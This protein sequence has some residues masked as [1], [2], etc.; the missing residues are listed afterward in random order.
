MKLSKNQLLFI[1]TICLP[2]LLFSQETEKVENEK[3]VFKVGG[4][5]RFNY[6]YSNWKEGHEKRGGDFGYD[7]LA[8]KPTASYKGI[9]LNAELRFYSTAFGG[10]MLKQ[11]WF[12]YHFSEKNQIQLGL[13]QVPFGITTYNSHNWFF[14]I[15]YYVG[16]E[17][18]HDMGI[19][20]MH[21][22]EKWEYNIAFFKNAEEMVFGSNSDASMSRYSYDAGSMDEN[23]DG[24][25]QYRNKEVNQFNGS[26][27][28]KF[29]NGDL[30]GKLGASGMYGGLYNLDTESTGSHYAAA[31]HFEMDYKKWNLKLQALHYKWDPKAPDGERTDVIAMVAYGAPY[32]V[33]A[34]ASSY[35]I[36]ASFNQPVE[37][38]PVSSLTFYNDFG[39]MDKTEESFYDS[40]QNVTGCMVTAG[41]M[42]TY[43]DAAYGKNQSWLG[44][45]YNTSMAYG[46]ENAD[47]HLRFNINF[48][49]YF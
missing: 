45:D 30:K 13:T 47:W 14:S 23:G 38:G 28:R 29:G 33:A 34:E 37:W 15:N 4:A 9:G 6:N 11:G 24:T 36:G 5:L 17:D 21:S 44:P 12:D 49:F 16:L 27:L 41:L 40:Y 31:L 1:L 39:F 10:M 32:L 2:H 25:L 19:K 3:P 35:T 48:G 26:I 8:I 7:M 20:Y 22:D 42:Y 46:V 18:D 43:I